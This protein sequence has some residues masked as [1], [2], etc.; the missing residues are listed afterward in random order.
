M[1]KA[2]AHLAQKSLDRA[3]TTATIA[4]SGV[5]HWISCS[6][7]HYWAEA[8]FGLQTTSLTSQTNLVVGKGSDHLACDQHHCHEHAT[9][10]D[11]ARVT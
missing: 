8:D 4:A 10:I 3:G 5:L 7:D 6:N 1:V 11:G 2:A 9:F